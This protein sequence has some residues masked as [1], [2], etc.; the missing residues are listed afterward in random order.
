MIVIMALGSCPDEHKI[1]FKSSVL[2]WKAGLGFG[3]FLSDS[4]D[5]AI[6]EDRSS[7][8]R[9]LDLLKHICTCNGV[10]YAL[11]TASTFEV[12]KCVFIQ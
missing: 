3:F 1:Y 2:R 7:N 9:A 10:S 12:L 5:L 11:T 4:L 8:G 6:G